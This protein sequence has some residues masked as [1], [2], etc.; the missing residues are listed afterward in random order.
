MNAKPLVLAT[1][2]GSLLF[3]G[4]AVAA[5]KPANRDSDTS[6]TEL[7][8]T[9][10]SSTEI[11]NLEFMREEEKLARDVYLTLDGYWGTQTRVFANIAESEQQ[12]TSSIDYLLDRYDIEDPVLRDEIGLFTNTELQELYDTLV[13]K[14]ANS[15]IDA[16]YVG[17]LIEEVDMEDITAAIQETDERPIILVYSNLLD[18]SEN[19]LRGFVDV[20]EAQGLVYEAQVL[21]QHEVDYILESAS[22]S[23]QI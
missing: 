21:E 18:G 20:I 13:A 5:G 22:D 7:S 8:S 11:S 3:G 10:L 6:S 12:H 9:E 1:V 15:L 17:A 19:H 2:I 23:G 16:L 4:A 14:G